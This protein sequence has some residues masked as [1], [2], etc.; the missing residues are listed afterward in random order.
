MSARL[1]ID[2]D[3]EAQRLA[4]RSAG[5]RMAGER[6]EARLCERAVLAIRHAAL[7]LEEAHAAEG[8]AAERGREA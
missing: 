3:R 8:E 2:M 5:Y 7:A 1:L 4:Q 6:T